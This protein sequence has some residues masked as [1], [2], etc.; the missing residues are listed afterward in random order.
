MTENKPLT[1]YP[2]IDK[3]WLKYYKPGAEEAAT[4]I[5][6]GK[7]V[8]DVIEE[9]LLQYKDIP[10]IEYFGHVISRPEFI[11]MVYTWARSFKALRVK[12]NEIVA[13]YGPLFPDVCAMTF[14]L[15]MIGACP[16]FVKLA[17]TPDALAEETQECR[18]AIVFE[19]M[20]QNVSSE[21]TKDRFEKVI[22]INA[23][24]GMAGAK[25]QIAALLSKLKSKKNELSTGDK[26][27][28]VREI[29][30]LAKDY[31]GEL[32]VPFVPERPAFI[33]SSSVFM[34]LL[35]VGLP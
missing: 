22:I 11:D 28:S 31:I 14:A 34:S 5:P 6:V 2:S 29:K 30:A 12:E 17:I 4:N 33:T 21:F 15:N 3:P 10:A 9:K 27:C 24:D 19:D 25:K 8:W 1:G 13:Y 20:W 16:Y 32:K 26:Y 7:T 18:I 23:A 35:P